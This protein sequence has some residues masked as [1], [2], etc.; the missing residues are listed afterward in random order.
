[1]SPFHG[2]IAFVVALAAVGANVGA[3]RDARDG[4]D[5]RHAADVAV[6][7]SGRI[8]ILE[9]AG[10]RTT[11]LPDA[12]V[13]L[14]PVAAQRRTV[15][16]TRTEIGMESKRFIPRIRVVAVGSTVDF[17]NLDPFRHNVFSNAGPT[18]FDLGLYGRGERRG[19]RFDRA[20]VQPIFCNIHSRMIAYVIAVPTPHFAQAAPDGRFHLADVQPGRYTLRSWHERGGETAREVDVPAS[21]LDGVELVLDARG[22]R[23]VQHKNKFGQEY[24]A[25]GR[26]RY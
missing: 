1:M 12:V 19:A 20:G 25:T 4:R 13:W 8:S 9:R 16:A 15:A 5:A 22:Y 10:E 21:G 3:R 14:E 18:E 11:D 23:P 17:P 26:D 7:V 6:V 24:T 2:A